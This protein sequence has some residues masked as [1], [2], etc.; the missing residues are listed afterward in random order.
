MLPLQEVQKHPTKYSKIGDK[1]W[2]YRDKEGRIIPRPE[3]LL[4]QIPAFLPS[5]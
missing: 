5:A 4:L 1:L 3:Y 2:F